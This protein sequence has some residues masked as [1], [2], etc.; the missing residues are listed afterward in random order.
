[1]KEKI[2]INGVE[3][4]MLQTLYARSKETKKKNG[5]IKDNIAVKIVD[6]L[7]YDFS[8]AHS[9]KAMSYGVVARTIVLDNLVSK[10]LNEHPNTL[11]INLACGLDTRCYRMENKYSTWYNV[12]LEKTMNV[13]RKFLNENGPIYQIA[14]SAMDESYI[15]DINYHGENVLVIIEGLSMYL[16]E[17]DI[18]TIFNILYKSFNNLTV[19]IETMSPFVVKHIKEKSIEG[20]NA[21]FTWGVKNGK[22]LQ[23]I[24]LNF[25]FLKQV[26]LVEGM[27]VILPIYHVLG[28]I[29]LVRNISNKIIVLEKSK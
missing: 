21:K 20:S 17:E 18:K 16:Q 7:D 2:N 25:K 14:K 13:R 23:K 8:K 27:K 6:S 24:L 5:K 22:E 3:E 9:D 12:D 29:P 1:M 4:T 15:N 28:I 19:M 11:V 26:S 10:Y